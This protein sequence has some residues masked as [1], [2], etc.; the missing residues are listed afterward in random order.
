MNPH[1]INADN[2][3]KEL[4]PQRK[5]LSIP[6]WNSQGLLLLK[7]LDHRAILNQL[8]EQFYW[9]FLVHASYS[10]DV[11]TVGFLDY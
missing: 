2:V 6:F 3:T 9:E 11:A 1:F 10:P 7:F 4:L 8:L 5:V